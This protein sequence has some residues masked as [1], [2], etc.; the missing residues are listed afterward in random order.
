MRNR[1]AI[2][3]GL[4]SLVAISLTLVGCGQHPAMLE[5]PGVS[6]VPVT[7][8]INQRPTLP[9]GV[10]V[11]KLTL[12][13]DTATLSI[14]DQRQ[15]QV[16][17]LGSDGKTYTDGRLVTWSLSDPQAATI[18]DQGVLTPQM[19]RTLTV[20]ASLQDQFAECHITINAATYTWQQVQTPTTADLF[21]VKMVST[22]EA[23]AGGA[24]GVVL[25]LLNGTWQLMNYPIPQTDT[26]H[27]VD[28]VGAGTGWMV[29]YQGQDPNS[30]SP[31][32]A[33]TYRN[34]MWYPT[35][36]GVNGAL[37]GVSTI[38]E[39]NAWAVGR[40]SSGKTLIMHWTGA[41]WA[42]DLS[43]STGGVL[44]AI[45]M[46]GGSEGWAVGKDGGDALIL[47]YD[48]KSWKKIA[49]PPFFGTLSH[50]ELFGMQML[51]GQQGYAV[52]EKTDT[53]GVT[54]GLM[55]TYD[56]RSS[57]MI[58]FSNWTEK[59]AASGATRFLDQVPLHGI[60]MV[61]TNKGYLLGSVVSPRR[62]ENP[63]TWLGGTINDVY[64][65]LLGFDGISYNIDNN[66]QHYSLSR[67]FLSI[68]ML[69]Q[70]DGCI[71]GRQ[72]Y[73]MQR[74]YDWRGT[75]TSNPYAPQ[76][77]LGN[78]GAYPSSPTSPTLAHP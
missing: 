36:I 25:H 67:D 40:D 17:I 10:K 1:S 18:N 27:G 19:Q 29:G 72:G 78:G 12:T 20:R 66:F 52:G 48:G 64:G 68:H 32:I 53:L 30:P 28:F 71:V 23:W 70:G 6:T 47:H 31:A 8:L 76:P 61:D 41:S 14:G 45:Q 37:L 5:A 57:N 26:W 77:G 62:L 11:T 2:R 51:N 13:P 50:S 60:S 65:N 38:D 34:G 59:N 4:G 58:N 16:S 3:L 46:L 43:F 24:N 74:A 21:G 73:I 44:N 63:G 75:N 54:H 33:M 22:R 56:G 7:S 35:P 69:P 49:L 15:L 55:L 42:R 39:N 9:A